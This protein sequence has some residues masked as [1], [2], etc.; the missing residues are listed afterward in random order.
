MFCFAFGVIFGTRER[1][2]EKHF[3]LSDNC[4]YEIW[5]RKKRDGQ[6]VC[7]CSVFGTQAVDWMGKC[8]IVNVTSFFVA[9]IFVIAGSR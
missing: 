6:S 1:D 3:F 8:E 2:L 4:N 7:M 9:I 5:E